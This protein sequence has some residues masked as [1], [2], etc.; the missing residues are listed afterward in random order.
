M[1]GSKIF[2]A[3][4]VVLALA[5]GFFLGKVTGT[6]CHGHAPQAATEAEIAPDDRPDI[7]P[8]GKFRGKHDRKFN[9]E[10]NIAIMDS[11]LQVTPEQ[12][13]LLEENRVKGDSVFKALRQ[14]KHEAEKTLG[15]ALENKDEGAITAA[16]AM[17][18][19]VEKAMLENR[20]NGVRALSKIFS[21]E[22]FK[23][24]NEYHKEQMNKFKERF[25]NSPPKG[26]P[27]DVE[28]NGEGNP[29]PPP[30]FGQDGKRGGEMRGERPHGGPEAPDGEMRGE[31]PRGEHGRPHGGPHGHGGPG[32]HDGPHGGPGMNGGPHGGPD[33]N[34]PPPP[35]DR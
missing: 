7:G 4:I 21:D 12:K 32:G 17:I 29:P 24:F 1:N 5:L 28:R 9:S 19:E 22:Q 14:Q 10:K 26:E 35:R 8:R 34:P 6:C 3:S 2:T 33:G 27:R 18:L 30:E 15:Q 31:G 11:I 13:K 20:I 16:K 23:K 25:K